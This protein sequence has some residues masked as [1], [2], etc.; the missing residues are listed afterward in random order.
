MI[1]S[2]SKLILECLG[3]SIVGKLPE[4][5]KYI[6]IIGP[7]TS[8]WDFVLGMIVRN[9]LGVKI[10]FL[11]KHQLFYPP[12]GWL[13]R[14]LGGSPV[15]RNKNNNLV[16]QVVA[17]YQ[18]SDEFVLGI[19]PEG[20]RSEIK[21]WKSG[22]YHIATKANIPIEMI[23]FDFKNREIKIRAPLMPTGDVDID[24]PIILD[25]FRNIEGRHPKKIPFHQP[26]NK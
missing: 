20:T 10:R 26:I 24:F 15:Y 1:Q 23:G 21:R 14:W 9:V 17:M 5:K 18:E 16:D 4:D 11:A 7:H 13:F 22:F 19:A 3:W 25:Y 2:I 8:N 12:Y 6:V